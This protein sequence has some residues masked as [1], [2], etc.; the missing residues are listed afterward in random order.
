MGRWSKALVIGSAPDA[1]RCESWAIPD[2]IAVVCINNAWRLDVEWHF[3]IFAKDFPE[4]K[5]PRAY[6]G[7]RMSISNSPTHVEARRDYHSHVQ[8]FGGLLWCGASMAYNAG[9][10]VLGALGCTELAFLG[11]DMIYDKEGGKTHFYG[12]GG[13]DPLRRSL[14]LRDLEAKSCRLEMMARVH[15]CRIWNL[16]DRPRTHLSFPRISFVDFSRLIP[17]SR[18]EIELDAETC[19]QIDLLRSREQALYS[20]LYVQPAVSAGVRGRQVDRIDRAWKRL[21]RQLL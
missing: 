5:R 3:H 9:Y 21:R 10:W 16:S 1:A 13:K 12:F 18:E 6:E 4:E 15:G 8:R 7:V 14:A 2:E 19:E 20:G 11:C 17:E